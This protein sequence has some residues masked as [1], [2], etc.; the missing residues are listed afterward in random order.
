MDQFESEIEN[1]SSRKKKDHA[2]KGRKDELGTVLGRHRW[3]IGKLEMV[4]RLL[5]NDAVDTEKVHTVI[6][7]VDN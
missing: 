7:L 4:M 6:T 5:D 2:S 3:H 1:L